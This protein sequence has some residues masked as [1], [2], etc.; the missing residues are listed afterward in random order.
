[1]RFYNLVFFLPLLLTITSCKK[2]GL[3][4]ETRTGENTFSCKINGKVFLPCTDFLGYSGLRGGC[5]INCSEVS[6]VANCF[7]EPIKYLY[8]S[9]YNYKGAGEYLL[10]DSNS[11]CTYMELYSTVYSGSYSGKIY[12]STLTKNGKVIIT[13]DDRINRIISGTFQFRGANTI[14]SNDIVNITSGRFDI[15]DD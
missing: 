9:L 10:S 5:N 3:T 6:I 13:N 4:K 12:T 15:K 14:N 8:I 11:I 2:E 1:M 7:S